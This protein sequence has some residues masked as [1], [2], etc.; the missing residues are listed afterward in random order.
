MMMDSSPKSEKAGAE[1]R[2]NSL[3]AGTFN[4][5]SSVNKLLKRYPSDTDLDN[6]L[7][8]NLGG[9]CFLVLS[10]RLIPPT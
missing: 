4:K 5:K 3:R 9:P 7:E 10:C 6:E 2:R 8:L 1:L